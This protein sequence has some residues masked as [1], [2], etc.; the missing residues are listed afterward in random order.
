V[1]AVESDVVIAFGSLGGA[2]DSITIDGDVSSPVTSATHGQGNF[3]AKANVVGGRDVT[4][5]FGG[6]EAVLTLSVGLW[7][8]LAA[9]SYWTEP[10]E[11]FASIYSKLTAIAFRKV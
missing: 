1:K 2:G 5:S 10:G 7:T 6:G 4:V 11:P 8:I 3:G 9:A